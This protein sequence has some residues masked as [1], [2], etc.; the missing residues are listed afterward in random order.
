MKTRPTS[1]RLGLKRRLKNPVLQVGK[2]R[3][4]RRVYSPER[5]LSR[6]ETAYEPARRVREEQ[7][8]K[9]THGGYF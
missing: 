4:E 8:P 6:P 5:E 7:W 1:Q 9:V 2:A 3:S